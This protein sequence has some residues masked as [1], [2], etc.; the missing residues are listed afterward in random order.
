MSE[1]IISVKPVLYLFC[2]SVEQYLFFLPRLHSE[3]EERMCSRWLEEK[4]AVYARHVAGISFALEFGLE[5]FGCSLLKLE[6]YE[7]AGREMLNQPALFALS[8]VGIG[9]IRG[10][11]SLRNMLAVCVVSH[12]RFS[13]LHGSFLPSAV[14]SLALLF[15]HLTYTQW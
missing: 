6:H 11:L 15:C 9:P 4:C 1:E 13:S 12:G 8:F 5:D 7:L 10:K 14:A 3:C 2:L